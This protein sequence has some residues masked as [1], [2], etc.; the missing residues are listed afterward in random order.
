MQRTANANDAAPSTTNP[1]LDFS[2]L[3]RFDAI[4]TEHVTPAVDRLLA[5][6]RATVESVATTADAPAWD[7]LVEPL[8]ESLDRLQRAWGA[9]Q[10][11]NAVVNTPELRDAYNANLPK[12]IAFYT[13]L[14]QDLRLY[15]KYRA[16]RDDAAFTALDAA[17]RKLIDNE[18]R[19]FRLGG[20]ELSDADKATYKALQEELAD[21]ST[22][23]EEHLLDATN[24]WTLHLEDEAQLAGIPPDV[25]AEARA[26]AE[27][28]GQPGWTLTLRMPC[29]LPVMQ[30]ARDRDLR[31]RMHE[32]YA[33][34]ASELGADPAWDNSPLITRILE[35]R[36]AAARLL[37]YANYAEVSLV[38]KMAQD[39]DEVIAFLRDLARRAMPFAQRDYAELAAFARDQLGLPELAPW[40]LAF[41]A[42]RLKADRFAYSEQEVRQYFPEDQVLAGL[43]RVVETIYGVRIAESR[44]A[45]WHP[46]VRF[47]D[48]RDRHDTLVGQFYFDLYAR[49]GKQGG[50]W[51]DDAI[52]RRRIGASV[53]H[54]VAYLTCNLSAP[55]AGKPATFTH[56][57]VITIFHE[58]GHGLHQLLTRVDVA[59]VS[60]IQG[61]EWDAVELPSQFMENFCWEWD[62]LRHMTRHVDTGEPLPRAL[63]DKML[64]ARNFQSGMATVRQLEMGLFDMLLHAH[65]DPEARLPWPSPEAA[66]AAVL[67]EVAVTPRAAYDRF[68]H[69]FTHVFAG[70]YAAG[71]Y[72]YKWAE[73]LSADAFSLF[74]EEGVLSPDA[75]ARFRDEVLARGGSRPALE[76]FVAFRGR[77]PQL[78]AL[79][80][81]NGMVAAH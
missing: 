60:G 2:D 21:L 77:P 66:H 43:F 10:H 41:A 49:E 6:A 71:Y 48:I 69:G 50:A 15:A 37:G 54:P 81:H 56:D 63:F 70:G 38:P 27:A 11:L 9:V 40:D 46:T 19:D 58:F 29:Y 80:R 22:R 14:A 35:L 25:V 61:V 51:M 30:Y 64:A 36:R 16:L 79:L 53:Q 28:A 3:P 7:T 24:A 34:R 4:R 62:V 67:Q 47:F 57:E 18:L 1:L 8:T 45:T 78:D 44:A 68:M 73:V 20:A 33:T 52:N 76:S 13:D 72:S 17:Q 74:E 12:I 23:F 31:Q 5:D 55:V 32:A 59:G 39:P 42:E 26:A 75:G 65:Y